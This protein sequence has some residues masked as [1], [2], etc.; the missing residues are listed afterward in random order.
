MIFSTMNILN[1]RF[2]HFENE[3]AI[4]LSKLDMLETINNRME[5]IEKGLNN[6]QIEVVVVKTKLNCST[7]TLRREEKHHN[8][9]E[10]RL[11]FIDDERKHLE[12]ENAHLYEDLLRMKS[13][14]M[15]YNL[16]FEGI[17]QETGENTEAVVKK[18][19]KEKLEI[20]DD[21]TF[22]NVHRLGK[23]PNRDKPRSIIARFTRYEDHERVRNAV[24]DN[25]KGTTY[26]VYQQYPK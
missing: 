5:T 15:K 4:K 3:T 2:D 23:Q 6:L 7:E 14:S 26:S 25:L 24:P 20:D 19:V 1:S 11:N 17:P 22:Q 18:C 13:H 10:Q 8:S 16:I 12:H 21:I 9:I